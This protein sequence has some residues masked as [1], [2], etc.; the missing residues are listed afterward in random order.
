M[1]Y[2]EVETDAKVPELAAEI[3]KGGP[4]FILFHMDGCGH[5]IA[6]RPEWKKLK[7]VG[8][9]LGD[10]VVIAE[11]NQNQLS[12]LADSMHNAKLKTALANI[13]GFPAIKYIKGAGAVTT[14]YEGERTVDKFM[15]W[16]NGRKQSGG[17]R[18]R[19]RSRTHRTH[20]T[21]RRTRTHRIKH[22]KK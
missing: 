15:S 13:S 6:M 22:R 8:K 4:V 21:H 2:I 12:A 11:V 19:S 9:S 7:N 5:C 18:R 3:E 20:R 10:T 16:I 17:R 14:D 1:K